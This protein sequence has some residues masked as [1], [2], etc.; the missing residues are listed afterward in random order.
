MVFM[1][2]MTMLPVALLAQQRI[3][4]RNMK[5]YDGIDVSHYQGDIDWKEVARDSQIKFVYI[6]ATQGMTIKDDCY[7]KNIRGAR[8]YGL[9]CGSYHYLSSQPPIRKQFN[10]FKSVV[11]K[12]QQDLIPMVDVEREGAKGWTNRQLR[13]SL[14]LFCRLVKKHYGK[15][16]LIYSHFNFYNQ[17]LAPYFNQYFLFLGKYSWPQPR[18]KGMGRHNIWQYSERGRIRGIKGH[19]DL[20]RLMSGTRLKDIEL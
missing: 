5:K 2:L 6:K 18:I 16:P 15:S 17:A 8:R 10:F 12:H 7:K 19:V 3:G 4:P 20:D 13:D 11:K 1:V 14:R 9:K